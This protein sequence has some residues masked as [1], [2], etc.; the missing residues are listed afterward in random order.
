MKINKIIKG[1]KYNKRFKIIFAC[2]LILFA[3]KMIAGNY[4][5]ITNI[6]V[7]LESLKSKIIESSN[8]KK[9][10]LSS[11]IEM[12]NIE[13]IINVEDMLV[14]PDQRLLECNLEI[15]RLAEKININ[16]FD[17]KQIE[18]NSIKEENKIKFKI[19]FNSYFEKANDFIY[20]LSNSNYEL[21][22]TNLLIKNENAEISANP[23]LQIIIDVET[24][25]MRKR[26]RL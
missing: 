21:R 6:E 9:N 11:E 22:I 3:I 12:Q 5:E 7:E 26:E 16:K 8:L 20:E 18:Q 13:S 23:V 25:I 2:V 24:I 10:I 19:Q 15:I 14:N 4:I 1:I 17:L